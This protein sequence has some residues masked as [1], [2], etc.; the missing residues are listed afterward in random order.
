MRNENRNLIYNA[1]SATIFHRRFPTEM[2]IELIANLL[3]VSLKRG[4]KTR[5][6]SFKKPLSNC[7]KNIYRHLYYITEL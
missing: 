6:I 7:D 2:Y 1:H 3:D 5:G 4:R